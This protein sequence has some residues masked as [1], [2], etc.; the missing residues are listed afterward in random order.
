MKTKF[1]L[2]AGLAAVALAAAGAANAG[3]FYLDVGVNYHPTGLGKVN[4]TSTAMKN[5]FTYLFQSQTTI[6]DLD[7]N[8]IDFGDTAVINGGLAV[9][10]ISLNAL[11][12]LRPK[13]IGINNSNNGFDSDYYITFSLSNLGGTVVG[14]DG[15]SGLPIIQYGA[16]ILEMFITFDG[17]TLNNFMDIQ[18]GGGV[19]LPGTSLLSGVVDFTSV[20]AG[21]NN[22]FH[23]GSGGCGLNTGF[24]D[25]WSNCGAA[26]RI[27]FDADFNT[28]ARIT[29]VSGPTGSNP[30]TYLVSSNHD[31]SGTFSTVPEPGSMAL[32]GLGLFGLGVVNRRRN[33]A[34]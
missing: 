14:I 1:A 17:S 20:D 23:A 19:M 32:L 13:Q 12:D 24:Y 7:A 9:G 5:E 21:Y 31:G 16:G 10:D 29:T 11:T 18:L 22:L 30:V 2:K 4:P 33:S 15:L 34:K 25:I 3:L 27:D 8:G 28:N 6:N 26:S